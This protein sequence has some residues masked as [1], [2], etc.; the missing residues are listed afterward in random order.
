M[1][2]SIGVRVDGD[3]EIEAA[4]ARLARR[5]SDLTPLFRKIGAQLESSTADNFSG[6]H[7][8]SGKPWLKSRRAIETGGK[9]L[10]DHRHLMQSIGYVADEQSVEVG[11][12]KVYAARHNQG[13][14]GNESVQAHRRVM[15]QVFGVKLAK[16]ISV[17]VK[18]FTRKANTPKRQFLG[19]GP[20]DRE[21][22]VR[23]AEE[24]FGMEESD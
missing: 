19:I 20:H 2:D 23:F 4:L 11:T 7:E 24:F 6:G 15:S 13:H 12:N 16:P 22:I 9:T 10:M 3:D 5:A 14:S 1:A 21:D 8:P 18:A 17:N